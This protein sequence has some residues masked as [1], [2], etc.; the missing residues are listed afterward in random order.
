M[1]T[2]AIL[3]AAVLVAPAAATP[4]SGPLDDK[5]AEWESK[6]YTLKDRVEKKSGGLVLAAAVYGGKD[7]AGDRFETYVVLKGKA[8]LGYTHPAQ[9][10]LLEIDET[11]YGR[12]FRDIFQ[13]GSRVVAYRSTIRS[14]DASTL[15]IVA[16]KNFKFL[17]VAEFSEGRIVRD[18]DEILVLARDLPLG[19]FLSVGCENF[20]TISQTAF[21]TR[22]YSFKRGGFAESSRSHPDFYATEIKR[23]EAALDR[24]KNDLQKNAG[25]YLGL[26]LSLYYDYAATGRARQGW[27]RQKSFFT[28]PSYAPGKARTCFETMRKDLRG[29]LSIPAAWP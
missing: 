3:L 17:R 1:K 29:R 28:L 14:L 23:K 13:D 5:A 24:L 2:A 11:P 21:R 7:G 22:L 16:Y 25:E 9:A 20:G 6:G 10:E 18:G 4:A 15:N 8:Y 27:E 12:G 19:R 26:T